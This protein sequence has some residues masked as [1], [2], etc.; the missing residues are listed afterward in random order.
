MLK[1]SKACSGLDQLIFDIDCDN[2]C[3]QREE[4]KKLQRIWNILLYP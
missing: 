3:P 1:E 4:R 2:G